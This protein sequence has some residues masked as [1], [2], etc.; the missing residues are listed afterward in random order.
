MEMQS[1]AGKTDAGKTDN[2]LERDALLTGF[3]QELRGGFEQQSG[4]NGVR[5]ERPTAIQQQSGAMGFEQKGEQRSRSN[6]GGE[7]SSDV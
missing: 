1:I 6:A 5:T 4:S 3:E 2:K 7:H